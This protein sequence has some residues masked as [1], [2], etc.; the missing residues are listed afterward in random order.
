[1]MHVE[2]A[3]STIRDIKRYYVV[4]IFYQYREADIIIFA[5]TVKKKKAYPKNER[6]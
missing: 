1:M 3:L 2:I 6:L 5:L 4:K